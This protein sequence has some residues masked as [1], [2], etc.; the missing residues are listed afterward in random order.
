MANKHDSEER[1]CVVSPCER[2]VTL[3]WHNI[4]MRV[5]LKKKKGSTIPMSTTGNT[6]TILNGVTGVA[7]PGQLIAIMGARLRTEKKFL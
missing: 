3:S 4:T 1:S 5:Q 7:K 2:P 6:K